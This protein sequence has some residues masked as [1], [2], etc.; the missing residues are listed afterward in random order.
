MWV[1]GTVFRSSDVCEENVPPRFMAGRSSSSG[2]IA[3]GSIP[4]GPRSDAPF[5]SLLTFAGTV[6]LIWSMCLAVAEFSLLSW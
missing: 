2:L 6:F 5:A 1:V 3:G 4:C